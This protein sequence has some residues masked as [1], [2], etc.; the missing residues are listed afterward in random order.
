MRNV[1]IL[2]RY[3]VYVYLDLNHPGIW[4]Y[5]VEGKQ[6]KFDYKPIYVGKGCGDRY[7]GHIEYG[8]NTRLNEVI[9]SGNFKVMKVIDNLSSDLAYNLESKLIYTIGRID[10]NKGPLFN[11]SAGVHLIESTNKNEIGPYHLEFNKFIHILRILNTSKSLDEASLK[12]GVSS[13]SLYRY[14]KDYRLKKI[15]GQWVQI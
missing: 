11:E 12:L 13:R 9:S 5:I 4:S 14:K 3:Y 2:K 6:I 15:D 1:S 7:L 10:L 8:K